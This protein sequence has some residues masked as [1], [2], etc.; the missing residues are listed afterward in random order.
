MRG[1]ENWGDKRE[2]EMLYHIPLIMSWLLLRYNYNDRLRL[3]PCF[4]CA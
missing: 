4:A 1:N 2:R 3:I